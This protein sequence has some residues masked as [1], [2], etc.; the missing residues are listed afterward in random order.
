M[1]RRSSRTLPVAA[2]S[3]LALSLLLVSPPKAKPVEN[4]EPLPTVSFD[5]EDPRSAVAAL[6]VAYSRMDATDYGALLADD[7]RFTFAEAELNARH[8]GG[9]TKEDEIA[10]AHHLFEG[11]TNESGVPLPAAQT[12]GIDTGELELYGDPDLGEELE[13]KAVVLTDA[14]TLTIR[15]ADGRSH[16]SRTANLYWIS[17]PCLGADP[18]AGTSKEWRI[19]RWQEE[20]PASLV[21]EVRRTPFVRC[22]PLLA[23]A[24]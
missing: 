14:L 23:S 19:T 2:V 12:I 3:L 7:F 11:F 8:P 1:E 10:S 15:F 6:C 9:F 21:E 16:V 18:P 20:P 5:T 24:N 4:P 22:S 17:R 13:E